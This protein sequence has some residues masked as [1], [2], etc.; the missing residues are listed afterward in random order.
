MNTA[1][2][3]KNQEEID[4][5][6]AQIDA[7]RDDIAGL[8]DGSDYDSYDEILDDLNPEVKIGTLTYSPSQV[9]KNVDEIAY[10]CGYN[11]YINSIISDK[12]SEIEEIE[13]EIKSLKGE[14]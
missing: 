14:K 3:T 4:E 9:L 7:L 8:E 2:Q 5:L 10:N 11:D 13:A 12:E 1:D 6:E